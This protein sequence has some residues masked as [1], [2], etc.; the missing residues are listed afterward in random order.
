MSWIHSM[1]LTLWLMWKTCVLT[2]L[3]SWF[4][5]NFHSCSFQ[6]GVRKFQTVAYMH[7]Q[8]AQFYFHYKIGNSNFRTFFSA[9]YPRS[10]SF[11]SRLLLF[12][13]FAFCFSFPQLWTFWRKPTPS[14]HSFTS[15]SWST[16]IASTMKTLSAVLVLVDGTFLLG[17][18]LINIS[19]D[20]SSFRNELSYL[21]C[22]LV[23]Q[24]CD[25]IPD[26]GENHSR[27]AQPPHAGHRL[28]LP[29]LVWASL[30]LFSMIFFFCISSTHRAWRACFSFGIHLMA[31][32]VI[33]R[34]DGVGGDHTESDSPR[35]CGWCHQ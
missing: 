15:A 24:W 34:Q 31:A 2:S 11:V 6:I 18:L 27:G 4:S 10:F 25:R 9:N 7:L 29:I 3:I 5:F 33:S 30:S 1:G 12:R 22:L 17:L 20:M 32:V 8:R 21:L 26:D 16:G 14:R 19:S 28:A 13:A 23:D 35:A